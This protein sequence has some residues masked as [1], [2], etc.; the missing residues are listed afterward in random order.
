MPSWKLQLIWLN[1][2]MV[3]LKNTPN[4]SPC[5]SIIKLKNSF[6]IWNSVPKNNNLISIILQMKSWQLFSRWLNN[7]TQM[8]LIISNNEA[9]H[10][11][12]VDGQMYCMISELH[13]RT[14]SKPRHL[15]IN[16]T[17]LIGVTMIA[18]ALID[19]CSCSTTMNLSNG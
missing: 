18:N 10:Q 3:T 4:C 1:R 7:K 9:S 13:Y 12:K 8:L 14:I 2:A 15:K 11:S 19:D 6:R 17:L 16:I 5:D